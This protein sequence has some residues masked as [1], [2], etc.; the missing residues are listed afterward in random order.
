[1]KIIE[2]YGYS[3]SGKSYKAQKI[4]KDKKLNNFFLEISKKKRLIRLIIKIFFF[5]NIKFHD[6]VF[7]F[8][9]H[10]NFKFKSTYYKLKNFFSY[11]YVISFIRY[12][13]KNN[14][15]III[16]H[17][18]FQC[19]FSCFI[20]SS[21]KKYNNSIIGKLFKDYLPNLFK[22]LDYNIIAMET[23]LNIVKKRL[24]E[25]KNYKKLIFVKENK[26]KILDTYY[27]ISFILKK[28]INN[29]LV[30]FSKIKT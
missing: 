18:L 19:L 1:M 4:G 5:Y 8:K 20:Q 13:K 9:V 29:K 23:N 30:N 3:T 6:L 22:N 12:Y 27:I 2:L 14:Q 26:K 25:E 24:S 21:N 7:V 10:K 11:I 28:T 16:D 15:S 17:G